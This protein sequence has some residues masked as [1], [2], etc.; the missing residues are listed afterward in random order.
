MG[1]G[2]RTS[3]LRS[4]R[5]LL[6]VAIALLMGCGGLPGNFDTLSVEE[7]IEAYGHHLSTGGRPLLR[8]RRGIAAHRGAAAT[9]LLAIASSHDGASS[10]PRSEAM[11]I[12]TQI[13]LYECGLN[14]SDVLPVVD[15]IL[16]DGTLLFDER[17]VALWLRQVIV[18]NQIR[19]RPCAATRGEIEGVTPISSGGSGKWGWEVGSHLRSWVKR[20]GSRLRLT[21]RMERA[22]RPRGSR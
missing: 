20:E 1:S 18:D 6:S 17:T 5:A 15:Q 13:Q 22:G 7:K 3:Q 12:L 8:A 10:L 2:L 4:R 21:R 14:R 11:H 19:R 9:R 16:Q